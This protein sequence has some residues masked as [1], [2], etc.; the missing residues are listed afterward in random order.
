M[1]NGVT[2]LFPKERLARLERRI[3]VLRWVLS[4]LAVAALTVCIV[5]TTRANTRNLR[6]MMIL[7]MSITTGAGWIVIYFYIYGIRQSKRELAHAA[8]LRD[9]EEELITGT[10]AVLKQYV[11]IRGSVRIRK[12]SVETDSGT[13]IV[14]IDDNRAAELRRAGSRLTLHVFHGYIAAYEVCHESH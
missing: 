7:C 5:L 8:L 14:N 11:R 13:R 10:V 3:T 1:A 9:G 4:A 2:E 12:V 6:Q